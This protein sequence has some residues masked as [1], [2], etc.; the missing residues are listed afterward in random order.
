VDVFETVKDPY[1]F[2]RLRLPLSLSIS[3]PTLK[4]Y[5]SS[6]RPTIG[7]YTMESRSPLPSDL[8]FFF[9]SLEVSLESSYFR[10]CPRLDIALRPVGLLLDAFERSYVTLSLEII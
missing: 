6:L 10:T 8:L 4:T 9:F 1:Q 2:Y 3:L 5:L 7:F